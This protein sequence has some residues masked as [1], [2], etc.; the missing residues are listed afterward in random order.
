METPTV[1]P[2]TRL[3][4]PLVTQPACLAPALVVLLLT[5]ALSPLRLSITQVS[6]STVLFVNQTSFT[7]SSWSLR[8]LL[9]LSVLPLNGWQHSMCV[10]ASLMLVECSWA[11]TWSRCKATI[12]YSHLIDMLSPVSTCSWNSFRNN[13]FLSGANTSGIQSLELGYYHIS[14]AALQNL[15]SARHSCVQRVEQ[16]LSPPAFWLQHWGRQHCCWWP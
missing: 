4:L 10:C 5:P 12:V 7:S 16:Q 14:S 9:L 11:G 2:P 13:A 8:K 6:P 3:P 1:H 15:Y